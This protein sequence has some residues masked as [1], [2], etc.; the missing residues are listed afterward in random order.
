MKLLSRRRGNVVDIVLHP[1]FVTVVAIGIVMVI[2]FGKIYLLGSSQEFERQYAAT[3]LGLLIDS[4]YAVRPDVNFYISDALPKG[5]GFKLDKNLVTVYSSSPEDAEDA[6]SFW[7]TEDPVYKLSYGNFPPQK[8]N[9][10]I[11]RFV[12]FGHNL[13]PLA[14]GAVLPDMAVPYCEKVPEMSLALA[15]TYDFSNQP[16]TLVSGDALMKV[17]VSNGEKNIAKVFVNQNPLSAQMACK[18]LEKMVPELGLEG[19]AI[20]PVNPIFVSPE[21]VLYEVASAT[22]PAMLVVVTQKGLSNQQIYAGIAKGVGSL[23]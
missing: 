23:A 22:V 18:L 12:R 20:V 16:T 7:F 19:F 2:V 17:V 11:T 13:V 5:I 10:L 6:K 1:L 14:K 8:S 15:R 21:D 4:L 9:I 3:D